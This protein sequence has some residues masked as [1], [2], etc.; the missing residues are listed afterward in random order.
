MVA[1]L[2]VSERLCSNERKE[3]ESGQASSNNAS[4]RARE[5]AVEATWRTA[6]ARWPTVPE[7]P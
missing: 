3:V 1:A 6:L 2:A 7:G 5:D 4:R